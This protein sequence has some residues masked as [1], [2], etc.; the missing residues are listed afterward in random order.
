MPFSTTEK[1]MAE[2]ILHLR[3]E[4]RARDER[5]AVAAALIRQQKSTIVS[6]ATAAESQCARLAELQPLA[7]I[8]WSYTRG[9]V[10]LAEVLDVLLTA[11]EEELLRR[12]KRD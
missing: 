1:E 9:D 4:L 10:R 7:E 11:G 6:L 2:E 12:Q 3:Q 8:A 5:L